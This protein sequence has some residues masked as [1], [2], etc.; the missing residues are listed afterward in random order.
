VRE[1]ASFTMSF[2]REMRRLRAECSKQ[3][4]QLVEV[5]KE[6][7]TLRCELQVQKDLVILKRQ[8]AVRSLE[9]ERMNHEQREAMLRCEL[10]A[11]K[12]LVSLNQQQ[13]VLPWQKREGAMS[14]EKEP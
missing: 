1:A 6:V 9:E 12:G 4:I 11:Q 2:D 3:A 10:E 13:A 7:S 5:E 14:R 8:Q